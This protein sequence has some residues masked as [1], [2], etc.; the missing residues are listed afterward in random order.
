MNNSK[1]LN[2]VQQVAT[3]LDIKLHEK[4]NTTADLRFEAKVRG[5]DVSLYFSNQTSDKNKVQAYF[6]VGTG[7][8]YYEPDFYKKITFNDTK[9]ENAIFRDL[10]QR[11]EMD[12]INE[13]VDSILKY[14]AD[15]EIENDRKNAELAAF[16]R[17]IPFEN[18]NYRGCFSG[19]KNGTYFELSQSKEQLSIN[20]RN[21]D[22][23]IRICAAAARI[24]EEEAAKAAKA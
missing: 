7:R 12:K 22:I 11:L 20:T 6:Y 1:I 2:I 3:S 19:R 10:V 13:K 15:K 16:Q 8:R 14:R 21:K 23:L 17:F 9:A 5:I 4:K 24:L 18:T